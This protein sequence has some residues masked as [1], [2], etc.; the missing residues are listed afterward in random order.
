MFVT[1]VHPTYSLAVV[2]TVSG[3]ER[4][5]FV[6]NP[7]QSGFNVG[8]S[9]I[10][11][12]LARGNGDIPVCT[13]IWKCGA[14]VARFGNVLTQCND[15]GASPQWSCDESKSSKCW[16]PLQLHVQDLSAAMGWMD[17]HEFPAGTARFSPTI[18]LTAGV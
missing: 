10:P 17:G 16:F 14:S 9:L 1:H 3:Q 13:C 4:E 12:T 6:V 7:A 8:G 15:P 5:E 11:V 2:K 18:M